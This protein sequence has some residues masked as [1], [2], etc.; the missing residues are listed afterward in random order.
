MHFEPHL[1]NFLKKKRKKKTLVISKKNV[2]SSENPHQ[3]CV[4]TII[5]TCDFIGVNFLP[6]LWL[7][8]DRENLSSKASGKFDSVVEVFSCP[9]TLSF[10]L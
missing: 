10:A 2:N 7:S 9:I 8:R 3:Y 5:I 1:E 4:D 6:D